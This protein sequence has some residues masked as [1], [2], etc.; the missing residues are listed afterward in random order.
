[1]AFV[2][3]CTCSHVHEYMYVTNLEGVYDLSHL[4]SIHHLPQTRYRFILDG[5]RTFERW[6]VHV[7]SFSRFG[8]VPVENLLDFVSIK[9]SVHTCDR[10]QMTT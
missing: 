1:M 5:K 6:R 7:F 2:S 10:V 3:P 8:K 4:K 9:K